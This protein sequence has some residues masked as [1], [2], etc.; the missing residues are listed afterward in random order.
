MNN[1]KLP[2]SVRW[3]FEHIPGCRIVPCSKEGVPMCSWMESFPEEFKN[4]DAGR[5]E[6]NTRD[7][8][9]F[10]ILTKHS[11]L[12]VIDS[13]VTRKTHQDVGLQNFRNLLKNAG[14]EQ[15]PETFTVKSASG[16]T[17][18][19]FWADRPDY[20]SSISELAPFV[21]VRTGGSTQSLQGMIMA[22]YSRSGNK[23]IHSSQS[24]HQNSAAAL[25]PQKNSAQRNS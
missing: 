10:A 12:V 3:T 6:E 24:E 1:L 2:K 16:R 11:T 19:Y 22:S 18:F 20:R 23:K 21:N 14:M 5:F 8:A 4:D 9:M 13:E 17:Q 25:S 15:L 7:T